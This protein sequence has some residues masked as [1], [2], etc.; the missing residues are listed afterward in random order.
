MKKGLKTTTTLKSKS[1][2]TNISN[3]NNN[4][5]NNNHNHEKEANGGIHEFADSQF[6]L[7]CKDT[8]LLVR[9]EDHP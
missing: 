2:T 3:I 1:T 8:R 9:V 6:G 7:I 4:N 5:N